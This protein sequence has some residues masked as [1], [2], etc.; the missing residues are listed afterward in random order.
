MTGGV[1]LMDHGDPSNAALLP[2]IVHLLAALLEIRGA[3]GNYD[4]P[5]RFVKNLRPG[6]NAHQRNL[7]RLGHRHIFRSRRSAHEKAQ[8][9]KS[10]LLQLFEARSGVIRVITI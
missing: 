6:K 8:R 3:D 9:E 4:M 1:F 10:L 7:L 5:E 2:D